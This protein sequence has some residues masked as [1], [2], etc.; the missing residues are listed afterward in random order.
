M[1]KCVQASEI[2]AYL[3]GEGTE[4]DRAMLRSHYEQCESC[5]RELDAMERTFGTLG[6]LQTI[7]PSADCA[8]YD[9]LRPKETTPWSDTRSSTP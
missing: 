4:E 2:T 1:T 6:R 3:Q 9:A 7:E 5:A 8:R